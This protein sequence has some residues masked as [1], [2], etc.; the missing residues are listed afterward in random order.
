MPRCTPDPARCILAN[1][2]DDFADVYEAMID[3]PKRLAHEEPFYRR[4]FDRIGARR[5][6]DVACGTGH[7]AAVF[8]SWGLQV[9][10]ADLSPAMIERAHNNFGQPSNLRWTVRA[11]DQ[12]IAPAELF[13]VAVCVGNSLALAPD[14]ATVERAIR[15]MLAAVRDGGAIIV[16]AL[17]LWRLPDGPCVWQKCMRKTLPSPSKTEPLFAD[18]GSHAVDHL[19]KTPSD[20]LILKGV[21]R[22]GNRGYV[23]LIVTDLSGTAT[24]QSESTPFLGLEAADLERIARSAGAKTAALFGG[25][26][27]QPYDRQKSVDLLMIAEK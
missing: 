20:L 22:C 21:H 1:M 7:H 18:R 4:L 9:E 8:H 15:Q 23:E 5:M 14:M 3:W 13:D 6:I 24:M 17:N 19:A 11:F 27:D 26:Q 10:G 2:F 16:Q 12:P 25:Y